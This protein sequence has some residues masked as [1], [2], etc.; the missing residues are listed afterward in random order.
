ML[1]NGVLNIQRDNK[2]AM[3]KE[4]YDKVITFINENPGKKYNDYLKEILNKPASS[5]FL[6]KGRIIS[7][8]YGR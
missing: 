8:V 4:L 6:S 2:Y 7:I 3:Y 1:K 5:F